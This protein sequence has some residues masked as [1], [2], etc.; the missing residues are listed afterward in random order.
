MSRNRE[1]LVQT[2]ARLV[3]DFTGEISDGTSLTEADLCLDS[4]ALADLIREIE[5]GLGVL[6]REDEV[7][8]EVFSTVGHL[9]GFLSRRS[10]VEESSG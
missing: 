9:L 1:W 7:S 3:P 10:A 5:E 2:L 6:I 8:P 4:L